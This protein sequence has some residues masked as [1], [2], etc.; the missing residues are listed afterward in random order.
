MKSIIHTEWVKPANQTNLVSQIIVQEEPCVSISISNRDLN[1]PERDLILE[2]KLKQAKASLLD[3]V[4]SQFDR[5]VPK[6]ICNRTL[7]RVE[8]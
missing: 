3:L 2:R 6:L 4:S 5:D 7:E 8:E 1:S